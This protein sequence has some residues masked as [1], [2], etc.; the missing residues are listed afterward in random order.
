MMVPRVRGTAGLGSSCRRSA[1]LAHGQ[2]PLSRSPER[3][4]RLRL[5]LADPHALRLSLERKAIIELAESYGKNFV[6]EFFKNK[7]LAQE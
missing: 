3:H 6:V 1:L 4:G 5:S 2:R 7:Y